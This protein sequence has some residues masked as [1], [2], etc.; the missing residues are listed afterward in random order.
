MV[1]PTKWVSTIQGG[2]G[3]LPSTVVQ[4]R[5][6][7]WIYPIHFNRCKTLKVVPMAASVKGNFIG[8]DAAIGLCE[9]TFTD[10]A[11]TSDQ[12]FPLRNGDFP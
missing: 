9:R 1:Y 11:P 8:E 2:A 7:Y 5:V 3:F 12:R 6:C 10:K 4:H